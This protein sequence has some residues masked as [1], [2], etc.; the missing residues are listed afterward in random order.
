MSDYS[1]VSNTALA[2][3]ASAIYTKSGSQAMIE[4]DHNT[5]FADAIEDIPTGSDDEGIPN[6]KDVVFIDYDGTIV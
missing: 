2:A 1:I 3:T 5:G 4:F 6:L